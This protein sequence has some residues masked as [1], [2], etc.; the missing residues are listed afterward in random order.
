MNKVVYLV[1]KHFVY[2][3]KETSAAF[4]KLIPTDDSELK[5]RTC[6]KNYYESEW[7]IQLF[8][9]WRESTAQG[10][11]IDDSKFAMFMLNHP[12]HIEKISYE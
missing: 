1:D 6:V 7:G 10:Y 12:D 8:D 4:Y 3:F 11:I 9:W 2:S 5:Y